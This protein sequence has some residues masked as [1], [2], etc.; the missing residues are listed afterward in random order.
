MNMILLLMALG[1]KI[2]EWL[3]LDYM[4]YSSDANAQAAY[5]S[6]ASSYD[7]YTKLCSHFDGAN[8]A[9]AY[10]DP[11]AGAAT[12]V[13][14]A[15]L[16]TAQKQF[17]TASLLLDG[18]GDYI[19]Y[20][21]SD[22]WY[23]G[24][25]DFTIDFW[26]RFNSTASLQAIFSQRTDDNNRIIC[27][28]DSGSGQL[29]FNTVISG[30]YIHGVN[31][32]GVSF[33][34]GTWYHIALVT[35]D[36]VRRIYVDGVNKGENSYVIDYQDWTGALVIG[37]EEYSGGFRSY[38]NGWIDEFRISKGIARWTSNFTPDTAAYPAQSGFILQD[39]SESTIKTQGS[40]S[41]KA[42]AAATDSL[43]KTLTKTFSPALDLS[44]KTQIK[45]DIRASRTGSNIKLGFHDSGGTT[46]EVTPNIT[47]ADTFQTVTV[48]I[49]AVADADKDAIDSLI[50]TIVNAD[51]ANTIYIDNV[52]YS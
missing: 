11:I 44:G 6:N 47:S 50:I 36:S 34:T 43:N 18:N 35:H 12:F 15:Q 40:Y 45:F 2:R 48:D 26:I 23:F 17:G 38:F 8:G 52:R 31:T 39:F 33:S 22:S 25:G 19:T 3:E 41:L 28:L 24:T 9:T 46:T 21:D 30:D 37:A 29:Y 1:R 49:S 5:V 16:S 32:S 10:T 51:S 20:P 42:V 27:Y 7:S 4:E 13:G 14:N